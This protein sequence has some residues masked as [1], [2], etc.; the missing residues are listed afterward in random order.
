MG[1]SQPDLA[2]FYDNA[3]ITE[4]K[5][6]STVNGIE[7][8][9]K[10]KAHIIDKVGS[11]TFM[12]CGFELIKEVDSRFEQGVQTPAPPVPRSGLFIVSLH[13]KQQR[14]EADLAELKEL[15]A[16]RH[17]GLLSLLVALNTKLTPPAP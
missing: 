16:K 5:V 14:M 4:G 13:Q 12:V 6:S 1:C 9:K 2:D 17:E 15:S 10:V 3:S 7:L 8:Q 11:S